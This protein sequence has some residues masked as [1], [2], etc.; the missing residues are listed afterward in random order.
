MV[1]VIERA[2]GQ[3]I[4]SMHAN[5]GEQFTI[6]DMARTAN[7]SKF[8]FSRA[9]QRVTGVSPGRFLAAIRLQEAKRLLVATSL[10]VTDISHRVGYTSVGTFSSRFRSS[11]GVSPT[12][13]RQSGGFTR[14]IPM[15]RRAVDARTAVVQGEISAPAGPPGLLFIG[16]FQ[17]GIPQGAPIRCTVLRRPG[18]YLLS[19]VPPG[20][21]HL[22]A[23]SVA[24]GR[25]SMLGDGPFAHDLALSVASH[26]PVTIRPGR[27][28]ERADLTLRPICN[29]DPPVLLALLDVRTHALGVSANASA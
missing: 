10:T 14:H 16:L 7:Y 12:T 22:L 17:D 24:L 26:G 4:D 23:Q 1:Q 5:I 13:F 29:L 18:S 11:V 28:V 15:A 2:V 20:T 21:W 6:D 25:E 9:F 3:V 8:H 19:C 27:P